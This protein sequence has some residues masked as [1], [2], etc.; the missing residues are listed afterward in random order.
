MVQQNAM[1]LRVHTLIWTR[2]RRIP[3]WLLQQEASITPDKAKSLLSDYIHTIVGQ[4]R[5]KIKC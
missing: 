1:Q 3:I 2:D 5:G 4:H